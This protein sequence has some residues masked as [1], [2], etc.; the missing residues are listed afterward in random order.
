MTVEQQLR[1]L[2]AMAAAGFTLG[3]LF[4]GMT[5]LRR[6]LSA[7]RI[8]TGLMDLLFGLCCAVSVILTALVL[9]IDPYRLYVFAGLALGMGAYAATIGTFVRII[10][11][12]AQKIGGKR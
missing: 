9:R 2:C 5:L 7:G 12:R 10:Q 4:D 6:A 3:A 1:A 8:L 11:K